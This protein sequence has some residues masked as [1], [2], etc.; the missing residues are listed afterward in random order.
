MYKFAA[1]LLVLIIAFHGTFGQMSFGGY[2]DHPELIEDD[3]TLLLTDFAVEYFSAEQNL[4]L[5]NLE[6]TRVRIQTV[7]G[8]NYKI[9]FTGDNGAQK[10]EC[11]V[12]V[13]LGFNFKKKIF[14]A[15]CDP[16]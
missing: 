16:L 11:E 1:A 5:T 4:K 15:S 6:I 3:T 7:S 8:T 14:D 12:V 13:F 9:N 2:S 10:M